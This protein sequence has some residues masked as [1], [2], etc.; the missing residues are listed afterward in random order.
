MRVEVLGSGTPAVAIVGAVH[1]DEPCGAHA[2]E[3]LLREDP[4]VD[5][6]A[7]L[8][9]ANEVALAR[10]VRFVDA[11]LNRA[12]ADDADPGSHEYRL[13]RR[14]ADELRGLT[15]LVIHSTRSHPEPFGIVN[16]SGGPAESIAPKLSITALVKVI[17]DEGRL[18][19]MDADLLEVEAGLQGTQAATTNASR[20][21]REFLVA[22]NVL[23]GRAVEREL[24]VYRLGEPIPKPVAESYEVFVDN[25]T[26]VR[27]GEP[28]A[29]ADGEPLI[30]EKSFY[31]VLL[32]ADG[33]D[34]Q[35]G[36]EATR[37]GTISRPGAASDS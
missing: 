5:R 9:I 26:R 31:P 8:I 18:F 1:G 13:A 37:V 15:V 17:R 24:P 3:R 6:P 35:F 25:F 29:A 20:I 36:Y 27:A 10:G 11:D 21:A 14:L 30:A 2:V 16:G 4:A 28:Y 12:F 33:Y 19:A 22:T 34:E 32:S 7:K 23:P